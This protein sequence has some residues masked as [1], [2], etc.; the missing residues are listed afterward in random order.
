[1]AETM[2]VVVESDFD[3]YF[4]RLAHKIV[5]LVKKPKYE[6][7]TVSAGPWRSYG[8]AVNK[9]DDKT[10]NLDFYSAIRTG[11]GALSDEDLAGAAKLL[12]AA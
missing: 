11:F 6:T 12:E 8:M 9:V 2:K 10:V 7:V 5:A 4:E 3:G 1:M